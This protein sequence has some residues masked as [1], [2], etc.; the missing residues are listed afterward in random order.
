[1]TFFHDDKPGTSIAKIRAGHPA[2]SEALLPGRRGGR[3]FRDLGAHRLPPPGRGGSPGH[4]DP[5]LRP[6]VSGGDPEV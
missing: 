6:G 3:L 5:G 1:M 2:A 4:P